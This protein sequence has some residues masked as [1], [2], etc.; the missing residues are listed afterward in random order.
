MTI[1]L[2]E[3]R[4]AADVYET[5]TTVDITLEMA[6]VSPDDL[7]VTLSGNTIVIEG[8][9]PFPTDI[10]PHGR[11]HIVEIRRGRFRAEIP[12]STRVEPQPRELR[13]EMGFLLVSF[14]R[15]DPTNGHG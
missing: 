7:R 3:W 14:T 11:Y 4:P 15:L 1:L 6:G 5:P 13:C 12:L 9:R 10:S 8:R 2:Q